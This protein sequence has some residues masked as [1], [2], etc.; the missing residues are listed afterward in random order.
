I[1]SS[2]PQCPTFLICKRRRTKATTSCEVMPAALSTS[3]TPSGVMPDNNTGF[4]H[5]FLR[6]FGQV[7]AHPGSRG[8]GVTTASETLA[9]GAHI[10]CFI[11]RPHA[12]AYF[13]LW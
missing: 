6:H 10:N 7:A 2:V 4:L 12:H 11:F 1:G 9:D 8:Q 5:D 13:A 3:R